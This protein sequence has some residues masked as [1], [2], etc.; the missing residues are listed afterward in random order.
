LLW[1]AKENEAAYTE[2][3]GC[4]IGSLPFK[5]L[6]IPIHYRKLLNSQWKHVK[7]RF[8]KKCWTGK[9]LSYGDRLVVITLVLTSLPMFLLSFF[10]IPIG[11]QTRLNFYRSL[12]SF[13]KAP[14]RRKSAY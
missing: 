6:G 5:Y 12:V 8:K 2:N 7:D 11:V 4:G 13:G 9:M 1:Q 10:E 14:I 3:F